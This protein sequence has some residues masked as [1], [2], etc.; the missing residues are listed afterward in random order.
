MASALTDRGSSPVA[1]LEY[2]R[3]APSSRPL[4]LSLVPRCGVCML[5]TSDRNH[6]T[7]LLQP[8]PLFFRVL[9]DAFASSFA[10]QGFEGFCT[11]TTFWLHSANVIAASL[12]LPK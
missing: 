1:R 3:D 10:R 2:S 5:R 6:Q 7:P 4:L 11:T 9:L 12:F 8:C